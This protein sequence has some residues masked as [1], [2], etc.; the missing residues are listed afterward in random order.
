[1][2]ASS[3]TQW[4]ALFSGIV[5]GASC[6]DK[7][8]SGHTG[9]RMTNPGRD[10][11]HVRARTPKTALNATAEDSEVPFNAVRVF[12]ALRAIMHEGK[13]EGQIRLDKLVPGPHTF[14]VGALAGLRGEIT[15]MDDNVWLAVP[16]GDG[17]KEENVMGAAEAALL[18]VARVAVWR[19]VTVE[20]D[21]PFHQVDS[22]V[23]AFAHRSGVDTSQPFPLLI[24]GNFDDLQW[25]VLNGAPSTPGDHHQHHLAG[26][27]KGKVNV[28]GTLIG[29]FSGRHEGIFT[30]RGQKTHFHVHAEGSQAMGH[31]DHVVI[32]AGSHISF[33]HP[34]I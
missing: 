22:S 25:H 23:A 9:E 4:V 1:M 11:A 27:V 28:R 10:A 16:D 29:F 6:G 31:V 20:K 26:A 7:H 15:I 30:H 3:F 13:T 12:G 17:A 24:R 34:K 21:I 18:V 8:K 5:S 32:R 14:A 2:R 19:D 33:P